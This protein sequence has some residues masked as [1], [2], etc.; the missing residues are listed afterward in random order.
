MSGLATAR[1]PRRAGTK[2]SPTARPRAGATPQLTA[3]KS[4]AP[5]R[6]ARSDPEAQPV[7]VQPPL[8]APLRESALP[9]QPSR[10][11]ARPARRDAQREPE[12]ASCPD[13]SG[14]QALHDFEAKLC[15]L[16]REMRLLPALTARNGI[17]ERQRLQADL[18]AGELPVPRF[19]YAAPRPCWA[20]LRWLEQL[21]EEVAPLPG[22]SLYLAKLDELEL[23]VAL[24]ASLGDPRCVR[25]LAARRFGTGDASI[26]LPD[27]PIRLIDYSLL[28][29]RRPVLRRRERQ[30]I[31]ADAPAPAP[32][33]RAI[34]QAVA[35]AA[36]V[37]VH[38]Q[39]EPNLTAGAATG[40]RTV[41]LADRSFTLREAWRLAIHEVL[42]HLTSAANGS[43]QPL[44]LLEWGS[45]FCFADQEGVALNF[46]HCF[47]LLD[48]GRMRSLSGRVL[49]TRLMHEG[50]IFGETARML[51]R[52]YGFCA[53]EA[54]AISERAYRGGGV[55]RD[56]G[57][58]LGFLRVHAAIARGETDLDELRTGR[59]G[60]DA[61]PALRELA[62]LGLVRPPLHRPNLLR[63]LRSTSTGTM[64]WRSPPR[65]A[66]SLI[67][68]ELT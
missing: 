7:A 22:A 3:A 61:L 46:E 32:S 57:Y 37:P 67:S 54:I 62:E 30:N 64:P 39:V 25:P 33:L 26:V 42:G 10:E 47:G 65:A 40:D 15:A 13:P 51:F 17:R 60:L 44:R 16:P 41:Y 20:S 53:S 56:A 68:V 31:P 38:V 9:A 50:A 48:R 29:L 52:D 18:E 35:Q 28:I 24:L 55:A 2:A 6:P 21:R 5:R 36:G 12:P 14:R 58:L 49:A 19:E 4:E 43:A 59:I 23:D 11:A 63:S 34:V 45:A 1:R 27:G 8:G 66:A